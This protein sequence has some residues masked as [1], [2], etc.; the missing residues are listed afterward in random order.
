MKTTVELSVAIERTPR[1]MQ[2]EGMFD[3]PPSQR[4]AQQWDVELPIEDTPWNV[5]LIVGPSG[6]GKSSVARALW[7]TEIE[8]RFDWPGDRAIL[9]GFPE[10]IPVKQL[11]TLLSSVGF[12][13]PPAWLRPFRCLS[14]GEQFRVTMARHLAD[15]GEVAVVDEF[16]S[17]VDR[18]VARIGSTAVAKTVRKLGRRFVAVTCHEDVEEWLQPDWVFR[19]A[20]REFTRRSLQRRPAIKLEVARVHHS[21]WDLFKHHHY[22]TAN[23]AK[24]AVCFVAF[25]DGVPVAFDAWLPFVGRARAR[26]GH[27]TVCLPDYQG[28]GIGAALFAHNASMWRALGYRAFSCTAHPAEIASRCSRPDLWRMTRAPSMTSLD[29]GRIKRLARTRSASRLTASFEYVGA[30]M[31]LA[32]AERLLAK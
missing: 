7:P 15:A 20:T 13:S 19:P 12:S 10:A 30:P 4:S 17:V 9:D 5:G 26:R 2:V 21:A 23:I 14:N 24:A 18:T 6:S 8:R 16:T 25:W 1:V 27:R 11:V 28:V 32:A 22:L 3:V 31:E 29:N